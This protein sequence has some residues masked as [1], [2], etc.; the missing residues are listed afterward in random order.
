MENIVEIKSLN[1]CVK[2][3]KKEK[4]I[5]SDINAAACSSQFIA[6]MFA[7]LTKKGLKR[8]DWRFLTEQEVA[9]LHMQAGSGEEL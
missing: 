6:L 4:V 8:G 1:L 7:G 3:G 5:F 2:E 9:M